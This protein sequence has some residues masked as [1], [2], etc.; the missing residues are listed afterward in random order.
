MTTFFI[1]KPL[2]YQAKRSEATRELMIDGVAER[3]GMDKEEFRAGVKNAA[4]F[5]HVH[6][7]DEGPSARRGTQAPAIVRG[8]QYTIV[9]SHVNAHGERM[10]EMVRE[11]GGGRTETIRVRESQAEAHTWVSSEIKGRR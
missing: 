1:S 2:T 7:N 3:A 6:G 5:Q 8:E 9:D 10:H 4:A 11:V